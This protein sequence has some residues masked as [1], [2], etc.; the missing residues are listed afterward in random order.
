MPLFKSK[1]KKAF[2]HNVKEEMDAHPGKEHRAQNLAIAYAVKRKAA[3]KM[4]EGGDVKGVNKISHSQGTY[5]AANAYKEAKDPQGSYKHLSE[6]DRGRVMERNKQFMMK[7]HQKALDEQRSMPKPNLP[8]AE[9][10]DVECPECAGA[11]CS[12]CYQSTDDEMD[13]VDRVMARRMSKGGMVANEDKITAGFEP[14]EFD[15]MALRDD[16]EFSY[17]GEN[18][19]DELG[20]KQEDHDREDIVSRVMRS[21]KKKDRNPRPA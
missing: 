19:G 5:G 8:M 2:E 7:T 9:G 21:R 17:T 3:Q 14:N 16:L 20:D 12:S 6:E 15:D 11:G 4:A 18:S 13:M 10:G 1:S